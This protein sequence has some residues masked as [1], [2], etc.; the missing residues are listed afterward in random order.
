MLMEGAC[1]TSTRKSGFNFE[2]TF[3]ILGSNA[4]Y[5]DVQN[6]L[7]EGCSAT[8]FVVGMSGDFVQEEKGH[9][10][11]ATNV[12]DRLSEA[13]KWARGILGSPPPCRYPCS[14]LDGEGLCP[15]TFRGC[16]I[17]G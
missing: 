8:T 9:H 1:R 6:A 4:P 14:A 16:S 17:H 7:F 12:V 13:I 11:T 2:E 5:L 15:A 3:Y 10:Y